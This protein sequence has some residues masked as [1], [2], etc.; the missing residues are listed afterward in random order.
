MKILKSRRLLKSQVNY[1][2]QSNGNND[3]DQFSLF[4]VTIDYAYKKNDHLK[5]IARNVL[6]WYWRITTI[7]PPPVARHVADSAVWRSPKWSKIDCYKILF[8]SFFVSTH[9]S[10]VS[11]LGRALWHFLPSCCRADRETGRPGE[12]DR[13]SNR[14]ISGVLFAKS[15][16]SR[17]FLTPLSRS[18]SSLG[19]STSNALVSPFFPYLPRFSDLRLADFRTLFRSYPFLTFFTIFYLL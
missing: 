11:S 5:M 15:R 7:R 17:F 8:N 2:S 4:N 12:R 3:P 6:H 1:F 13:P 14:R 9:S 10:S 19:L 16:P 18:L